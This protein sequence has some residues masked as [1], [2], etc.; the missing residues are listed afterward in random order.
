MAFFGKPRL[1]QLGEV[2]SR[3]EALRWRRVARGYVLRAAFGLAAIV[4]ALMTVVSLHIALWA[5]LARLLGPAGS[6]VTVAILDLLACL[7]LAWLAAR[8][9]VDKIAEQARAVRDT[10]LLGART[11]VQTLGG[12]LNGTA[13]RPVRR[14]RR[15]SISAPRGS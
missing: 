2:A 6:A 10:A 5:G 7:V 1:L 8:H 11:E 15:I 13:A 9:R 14:A 3:A 12:L 4:F